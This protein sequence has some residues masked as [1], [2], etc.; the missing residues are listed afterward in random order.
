MPQQDAEGVF[1]LAQLDSRTGMVAWVLARTVLA[2]STSRWEVVPPS[3]RASAICRLSRWVATFCRAMSSRLSTV[4][5][6]M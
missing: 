2:C 3:K 1:G 4:R 6:V 5:M